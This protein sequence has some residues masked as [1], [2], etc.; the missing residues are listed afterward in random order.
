MGKLIGKTKVFSSEEEFQ[1]IYTSC[2]EDHP[3]SMSRAA[4]L[5]KRLDRLF[6]NYICCIEE[7]M[8]RYAYECGYE[9]G[10]QEAKRAI[11]PETSTTSAT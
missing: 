10:V 6:K 3:R 9:A 4:G 5:Y 11:N 1:E 7:E 2:L 8:F